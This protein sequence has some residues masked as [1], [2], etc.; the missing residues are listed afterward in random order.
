MRDEI[1]TSKPVNKIAAL[2]TGI[3]PNDETNNNYGQ[4][5][6][7]LIKPPTIAFVGKRSLDLRGLSFGKLKVIGVF[8]KQRLDI[9][10][11]LKWLVQCKCGYYTVRNGNTI[12]RKIKNNEYDECKRCNIVSSMV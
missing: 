6:M 12:R 3:Q 8:I 11:P 5:Y 2:V 10:H 1:Y 4:V 9:R 7:S